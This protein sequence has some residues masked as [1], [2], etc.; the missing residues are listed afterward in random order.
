[1]KKYHSEKDLLDT[2]IWIEPVDKDSF[3]K[4]KETLTRMGI[5]SRVEGESKPTLWQSAH[6]LHKRGKYAIV[7]FKQMFMLDGRFKYT[8]FTPEDQDRVTYIASLLQRW[9][10]C[11]LITKIPED[12]YMPLVVVP[13]RDKSKWHLREKYHIG[14]KGNEND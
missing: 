9:G 1:M 4:I 13:Y 8:D 5:A 14:T 12:I 3:L 7:S 11:K 10:M 2:F 6:L